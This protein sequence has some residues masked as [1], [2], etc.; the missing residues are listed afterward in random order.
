MSATQVEK[1][2][3]ESKLSKMR[4]Q[5][6]A[7]VTSLNTQ[8]EDLKKQ[9]EGQDTPTKSKK[10]RTHFHTS[11]HTIH[12]W[13]LLTSLLILFIFLSF[14]LRFNFIPPGSTNTPVQIHWNTCKTYLMF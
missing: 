4:L 8:L 6:K 10:V 1:E 9:Q 2:T 11:T 3:Y 14:W 13:I 5:N 7:K 12:T